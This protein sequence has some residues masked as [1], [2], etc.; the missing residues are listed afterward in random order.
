[1]HKKGEENTQI[2]DGHMEFR[3]GNALKYYDSYYRIYIKY[4]S[5]ANLLAQDLTGGAT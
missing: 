3:L 1:M 5:M 4:N 2:A